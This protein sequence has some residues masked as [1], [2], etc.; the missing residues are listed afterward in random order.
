MVVEL[1]LPGRLSE[2]EQLIYMKQLRRDVADG[3][4]YIAD[5]KLYGDPDAKIVECNSVQALVKIWPLCSQA[6]IL[7]P[8]RALIQTEAGED[9]WRS[10][11]DRVLMETPGDAVTTHPLEAVP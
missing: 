8:G 1:I 11:L 6:L 9:S 7:G 4:I 3:M 2:L 5:R 10:L